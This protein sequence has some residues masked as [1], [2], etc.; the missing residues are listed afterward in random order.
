MWFGLSIFSVSPLDPFLSK[1]VR[2]WILDWAVLFVGCWGNWLGLVWIF[3]LSPND[4]NESCLVVWKCILVGVVDFLFGSIFLSKVDVLLVVVLLVYAFNREVLEII[5]F[6][7]GLSICKY[8][9]WVDELFDTLVSFVDEDWSDYW[10][11]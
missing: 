2:F 4:F 10:L 5:D 6:H 1:G 9:F 8:F 11:T 7:L 3:S